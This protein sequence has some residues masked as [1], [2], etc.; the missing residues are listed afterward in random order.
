MRADAKKS[1]KKLMLLGISDFL[2]PWLSADRKNL[3]VIYCFV[4]FP[5]FNPSEVFYIKGCYL[6][7]CCF[8]A[9]CRSIFS[10]T[11]AEVI[12]G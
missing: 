6:S 11:R 12:F 2:P 1:K 10:Q 7:F 9:L 5:A 4:H 8:G 3:E